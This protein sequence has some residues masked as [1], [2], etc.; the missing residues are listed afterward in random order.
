M[1]YYSL[2]KGLCTFLKRR[3]KEH[4]KTRCPAALPITCAEACHSLER[5]WVLGEM[6]KRACCKRRKQR[7]EPISSSHF[8]DFGA[9]RTLE[10][11]VNCFSKCLFLKHPAT[12]LLD[13]GE[14]V[15]RGTL[16]GFWN[17]VVFFAGFLHI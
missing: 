8:K 14:L 2:F 3:K 17:N 11:N 4:S 15:K 16:K 5:E 1:N 6:Y 13:T 9:H 10:W 7:C 12:I